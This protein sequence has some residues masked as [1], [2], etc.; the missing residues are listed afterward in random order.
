M[1]CATHS[2]QAKMSQHTACLTLVCENASQHVNK[3][4]NEMPPPV[5]WA[6]RSPCRSL[7]CPFDFTALEGTVL[8][9]VIISTLT[10]LI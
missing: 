9:L 5:Q 10:K 2:Q 3:Q 8:G 4:H 6:G 1:A 7:K